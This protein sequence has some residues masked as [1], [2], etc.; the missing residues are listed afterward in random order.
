MNNKHKKLY[1]DLLDMP[2]N[3][4]YLTEAKELCSGIFW[5]ITESRALDSYKLLMFDIP[6]DINGNHRGTHKIP[7]NAKSGNTY[8][9][10]RLWEDEIKNNPGH[11]SYNKKDFDHY[12]RGRVEISNS[13]ATIYLNPH[14]EKPSIIDDIKRRFGLNEHTIPEIRVVVDGSAHYRCFIDKEN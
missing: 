11:K 4:E 1:S 5:I 6:C 7:L 12:P 9:N 13:R 10:K 3:E 2:I 14:I 8:N